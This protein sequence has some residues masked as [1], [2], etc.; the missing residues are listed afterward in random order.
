MSNVRKG[1]RDMTNGLGKDEVDDVYGDEGLLYTVW[2]WG[3]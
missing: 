2:K 1:V 3:L